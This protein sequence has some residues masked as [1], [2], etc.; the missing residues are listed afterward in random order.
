M[1]RR[2][3]R[4]RLAPERERSGGAFTVNAKLAWR[5]TPGWELR[6]DL[7]NLLNTKAHDIEYWGNAC[8]RREGAAC[9]GG[10]GLAGRLV[11]PMEPRSL[12]FS[13]RVRL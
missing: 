9:G 12:R 10:E 2:H 6:L 4:Q 3:D 11:H 8:T 13:V 1:D 7:L 5:P